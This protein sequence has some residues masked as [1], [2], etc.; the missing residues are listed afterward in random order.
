MQK[1]SSYFSHVISKM[2][3]LPREAV[4][5]HGS[6]L[7]VRLEAPHVQSPSFDIS[8]NNSIIIMEKYSTQK[9][10]LTSFCGHKLIGESLRFALATPKEVFIGH[11]SGNLVTHGFA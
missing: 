1:I 8:E 11:V 4:A 6:P 2:V 5:S 7:F 9:R 3:V 10:N